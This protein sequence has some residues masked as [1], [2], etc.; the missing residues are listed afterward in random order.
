MTYKKE[1]IVYFH[2][3]IAVEAETEEEAT[4]AAYEE[5]EGGT[6]QFAI[7]GSEEGECAEC[8]GTGEVPCDEDDGEGHT[9]SGVGTQKCI[10]RKEQEVEK[11]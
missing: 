11:D 3:K 1:Y 4:Q 7:T 6:L 2:G 10:C 8:G 9:Q 5:L